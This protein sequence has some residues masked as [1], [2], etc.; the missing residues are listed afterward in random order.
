MKTRN[1]LITALCFAFLMFS[2]DN[3]DDIIIPDPIIGSTF[4]VEDVD[5]VSDDGISATVFL[6]IPNNIIVTDGEVPLVFR[7]D[8]SAEG[9]NGEEVFEPLP[10]TFFFDNAGF[11]QYRFNFSAASI[12]DG[13][14]IVDIALILE[15]DDFDALDID[16]TN[17]Q[18]FRIVIV[19]SDF[20]TSEIENLTFSQVMSKLNLE[21]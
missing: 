10:S 3:N 20:V 2:C 7:L 11:A 6:D 9:P 19:P 21:L 4:D 14:G 8:Q 17:N 18:I 1:L 16:F 5:F 12:N 13:G 15:S